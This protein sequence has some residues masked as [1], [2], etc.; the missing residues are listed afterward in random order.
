MPGPSIGCPQTNETFDDAE[1]EGQSWLGP[2][3]S[4]HAAGPNQNMQTRNRCQLL[5]SHSQHDLIRR[6]RGSEDQPAH[7]VWD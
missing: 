2:T 1:A 7:D 4:L 3:T 6:C 5:A